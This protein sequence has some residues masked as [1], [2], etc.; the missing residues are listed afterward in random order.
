MSGVT[1]FRNDEQGRACLARWRRQCIDECVMD[2]AAGKCGDQ[3]Y[4]DEWPDLYPGLVIS[5]NPG[6]GLAP[7]NIE[8]YS[9]STSEGIIQVDGVPAVF[10]HFHGLRL[11]RP[12][13]HVQPTLSIS[14][15]YHMPAEVIEAFYRPYA[16]EVW[17]TTMKFPLIVASLKPL[18]DL[19]PRMEDDQILFSFMGRPLPLERNAVTMA[20]LYGF[21]PNRQTASLSA[22][23]G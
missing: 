18:P 16:R 13:L 17:A 5:A 11:M 10:Y 6:I 3:N 9:V 2:P 22:K 1:A 14:G 4:L 21:D 19:H 12:R 8:K 15:N 23:A 20:Y 7:W